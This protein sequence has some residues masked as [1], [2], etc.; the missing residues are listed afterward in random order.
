MHISKIKFQLFQKQGYYI[1]VICIQI[2]ASSIIQVSCNKKLLLLLKKKQGS[3]FFLENCHGLLYIYW[4]SL[5]SKW[6]MSLW[7]IFLQATILK[8]EA[9]N[10]IFLSWRFKNWI[11]RWW[12]WMLCRILQNTIL[13]RVF[14][15]NILFAADRTSCYLV[16][17]N[18]SRPVFRHH[19]KM[20]GEKI[21]VFNFRFK[22]CHLYEYCP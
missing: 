18:L 6:Q 21:F 5:V 12:R 14:K 8:T 10:K 16:T 4:V 19:I 15:K 3:R 9:D 22:N 2:V 20:S 11:D 13:Q 17:L 1:Y 7:A